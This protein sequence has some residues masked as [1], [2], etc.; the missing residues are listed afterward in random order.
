MKKM[1]KMKKMIA[2]L[3]AVLMIAAVSLPA[4]AERDPSKPEWIIRQYTMDE[5][6]LT[7]YNGTDT[8]VE[9][10]TEYNGIAV[11]QI[12]D[13]AF[14]DYSD[15]VSVK[16]P[17]GMKYIRSRAFLNCPSLMAVYI[18][19]SVETVED[20]AFGYIESGTEMLKVPGFEI[21]G[22][23]G[24]AAEQYAKENG[25]AFNGQSTCSHGKLICEDCGAALTKDELLAAWNISEDRAITASLFSEG[26]AA[27]IAVMAALVVGLV[28]GLLIGRK[29]KSTAAQT[30]EE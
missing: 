19:G 1:K 22:V 30:K 12:G 24:S 27:C 4:A 15:L 26:S 28:G 9:I 5:S 14:I 18:P 29:K 6:E 11:R 23:D 21:S 16:I 3:L 20:Y 10:P 2:V 25:F 17:E 7:R 8:E 13:E